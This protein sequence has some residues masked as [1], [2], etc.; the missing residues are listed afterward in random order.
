[1]DE[2]LDISMVEPG[3]PVF[4]IDGASLGP[5]ESIDVDNN[6][7]VLTH[8]IPPAAVARV[9]STGVHLYLAR[10]A[11]TTAPPETRP[12]LAEEA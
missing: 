8:S 12:T 2:N 1:M 3:M 6:L 4:G 11:F 10:V 9:D 5:V 7:Q